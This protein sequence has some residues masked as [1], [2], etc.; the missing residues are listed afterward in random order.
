VP[1]GSSRRR[2]IMHPAHEAVGVACAGPKR[3]LD[4]AHPLAAP[5]RPPRGMRVGFVAGAMDDGWHE[6]R[7]ALTAY[8]RRDERFACRCVP[9]DDDLAAC[10]CL[11]LLGRP[12]VSNP[13][14]LRRIEE[15]CRGGR[16]IVALRCASRAFPDWPGFDREVLGGDYQ[17]QHDSAGV[18][19]TLVPSARRH[20]VLSGVEPFSSQGS[21]Y[22]NPWLAGDA[23]LLLV[24]TAD[25]RTEPVAWLRGDRGR[26]VFYTSLGHAADF[27]QASFLGLL[28]NAIRWACRV[29]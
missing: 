6:S 1:S 9:A 11:V 7:A 13:R 18:Q 4:R 24:G 15:H 3:R 25:D 29:E 17:G 27:R 26:R 28:G 12:A 23:T 19:V 20:P 2:F 22:E 14:L 16:P 10:Q 5:E 8:L 21:L